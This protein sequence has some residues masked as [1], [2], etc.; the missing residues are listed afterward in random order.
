MSKTIVITGAGVGLGRA[1]AHR[2]ASEGDNVVLLGRTLSKVEAVAKDI[3]ERALA[4]ACD[5]GSPDSVRSA[6]SEIAKKHSQIDV[7]INNAAVF[8][9]FLLENA[10]DDQILS[11]LATN[12]AGPMY[13]I[14]S[15]IPMMVRGSHII[16]V[17]SES[18]EV[19]L[20]HLSVYQ[21]SKAGLERLTRSLHLELESKGIRATFVRAGAMYE[22]GKTWNANPE[23]QMAFGKAAMERGFNMR[24][25]ALS[26]FTSV[27]DVFRALI[28]LPPDLHAV[29][30]CL[31]ARK[32]G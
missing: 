27:T 26:Q 4:V 30:I 29:S 6:F 12:L 32:G 23:D 19:E 17:T 31:H 8:E 5:V 2:F 18:V 13:C 14:R 16:N 21:A 1:L 3:G 7:L 22:E 11:A 24:E 9:P 20:P 10:K 25:K 15:A 28:D